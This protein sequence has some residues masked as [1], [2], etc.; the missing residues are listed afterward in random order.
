MSRTRKLFWISALAV[1]TGC[2]TP[3]G[4]PTRVIVPRGA[5]FKDATDSLA[6]AGLIS[7]PRL[8]RAYARAT[9][10]DRDIKPGTYLLKHG[11]PW[12]D[13]V[14]ALNGGKGL[15]NTITIPEGFSLSQI[16]PLLAKTLNV[17]EIP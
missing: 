16:V 6:H 4:A 5:S 13:I 12:K 10:G 2:G 15:V 9:S 14:S 3:H 7:W 17:P 1:A 11:T 8:C